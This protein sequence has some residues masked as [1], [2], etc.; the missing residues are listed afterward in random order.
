[1]S[2]KPGTRSSPN[3][4]KKAKEG[5]AEKAARCQA[6]Q[7][8]ARANN[9]A[10]CGAGTRAGVGRHSTALVPLYKGDGGLG[11]AGHRAAGTRGQP[12]GE[13]TAA[14]RPVW[15]GKHCKPWGQVAT[16]G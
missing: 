14:R 15:A 3:Q 2:N 11:R 4:K 6:L 7:P 9:V 5:W 10:L 12:W 13:G 8:A 16:W 1:M